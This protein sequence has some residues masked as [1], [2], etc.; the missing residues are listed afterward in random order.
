[1]GEG[2]WED[3]VAQLGRYVA[4]CKRGAPA[5]T[6]VTGVGKSGFVAARLASSL[7]SIGIRAHVRGRAARDRRRALLTA[8]PDQYL[9]GA[10]LA[11]GDMGGIGSTDVVIALSHSGETPELV[12]A[13]ELVR[14][15]KTFVVT[16]NPAS[17]LGKMAYK[18]RLQAAARAAP[19]LTQ[20]DARRRSLPASPQSCSG[21]CPRPAWRCR[22]RWRPQWWRLSRP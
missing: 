4:K 18:V 11:H 10:E 19:L 16:G 22:T 12:H 21:A 6:I 2:D 9:P 14:A 15:C 7:R 3:S 1:M 20:A 5:N 17:T 8:R 13:I